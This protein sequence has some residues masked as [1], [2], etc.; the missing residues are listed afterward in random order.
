M[1]RANA[2]VTALIMVLFLI[3][4]IWGGMELA[5]MVKGGS[6]LFSVLSR[7]MLLLMAVH[8]LIAVLLT[9]QTVRACRMSG[10][11]YL[12]QNRLF[13]IRRISGF[14]LML[15]ILCHVLIFMGTDENGVYRLS[16]FAGAQLLTQILMV[17]SLL[18]HLL[19][20]ITPLRIALGIEDRHRIRTDVMLVLSCLLFL[21]GAAFVIYFIRWRVI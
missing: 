3:H 17:V 19:C 2:V 10:V 7:V 1:R 4:M 8:F 21:A 20:N 14:A 13:W 16:L 9:A 15:F 5:G 6:T 18:V 11:F 12:K